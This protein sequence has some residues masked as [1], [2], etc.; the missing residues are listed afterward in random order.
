[1]L[2]NQAICLAENILEPKLKD[3]TIKLLEM[4]ESICCSYGCSAI[5]KKIREL[6]ITC[7]HPHMNRL[8]QIDVFMY[9]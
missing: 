9:L 1:M 6:G 5:Y 2:N 3:E 4:T 8:N 7:D